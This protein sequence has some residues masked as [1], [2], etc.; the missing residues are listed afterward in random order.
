MQNNRL[1]SV[2][3]KNDW[4]LRYKARLIERGL[5]EAFAQE[6]L[7]AGMSDFDYDDDPADAAD[8]ELSYWSE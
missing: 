4:Q 1:L 3:D 5:D 6:T 7:E 8:E 2:V